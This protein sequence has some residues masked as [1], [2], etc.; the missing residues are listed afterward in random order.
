MEWAVNNDLTLA[1]PP[2]DWRSVD[3]RAPRSVNVDIGRNS[4]AM[5][6]ELEAGTRTYQSV[7]AELGLDY[8]TE[9]RQRAKEAAFIRKLAN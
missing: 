4:S 5:L 9:L 8:R 2:H 3:T 7:Y 6:A 1:D